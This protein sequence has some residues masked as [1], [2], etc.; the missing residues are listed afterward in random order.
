MEIFN[1]ERNMA[2]LVESLH[3]AGIK[4]ERCGR[5]EIVCSFP[6]GNCVLR[7][8]RTGCS[9]ESAKLFERDRLKCLAAKYE[10]WERAALLRAN[11]AELRARRHHENAKRF[12]NML[13][14]LG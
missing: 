14:Q 3:A 2:E 13:E 10:G 12:R 11:D 5:S 4:A 9:L 6:G 1:H 7:L 8:S